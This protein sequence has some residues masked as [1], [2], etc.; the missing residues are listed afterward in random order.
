[1]ETLPQA[2]EGDKGLGR[3]APGADFAVGM[4]VLAR[5][6]HAVEASNEQVHTGTPV[7]AYATGTTA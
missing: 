5:R 1:M 4:L 3:E 2:S 6:A 7:F